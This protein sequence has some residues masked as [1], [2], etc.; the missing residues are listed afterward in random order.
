MD[1]VADSISVAITRLGCPSAAEYP[2]G[3]V[4]DA[5]EHARGIQGIDARLN[6]DLLDSLDF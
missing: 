2:S 1:G 5:F 3:S 4:P 6:D